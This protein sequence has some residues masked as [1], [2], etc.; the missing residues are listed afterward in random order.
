MSDDDRNDLRQALILAFDRNAGL[1]VFAPSFSYA[2]AGAVLV[3][4]TGST[5]FADTAILN[6]NGSVATEQRR[7]LIEAVGVMMIVVVPVFALMAFVLT[8]YRAARHPVDFDPDWAFSRKLE[9][10][11]W[12]VPAMIVLV[13]GFLLWTRTTSLDP[14]R[15]VGGEAPVRVQAVALDWKWLFLYPDD[16]IAAVNELVV[17]VDRPVTIEL[18]SDTV[19]NAFFIPGLAGQIYTMAGMRSVLNLR[20]ERITETWGRNTQ[21]SGEGF[22]DQDFVVRVG[23]PDAHADWVEA[24]RSDGTILDAAAYE[25]LRV[26]SADTPITYFESIPLDLFEATVAGYGHFHPKLPSWADAGD[27]CVAEAG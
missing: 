14:F 26:P 21:F 10:T 25:A 17:P 18:T 22:P 20:A 19:M 8:R 11:I 16:G 6:P 7:L 5:A 13:I 23:Q 3:G 24:V 4:F 2:L 1:T 9:V 15:V 27:V 12:A